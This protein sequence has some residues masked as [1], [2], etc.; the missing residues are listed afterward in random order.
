MLNI[1]NAS[2]VLCRTRPVSSHQSSTVTAPQPRSTRGVFI[3]WEICTR[4]PNVDMRREAVRLSSFKYC[5]LY[6]LQRFPTPH[7]LAAAGFF[8]RGLLDIMVCAFCDLIISK[9]KPHDSPMEEHERHSANCPFVLGLPVGNIPI[10]RPSS[11]Q[12][13][14]RPPIS[15]TTTPRRQKTKKEVTQGSKQS[16]GNAC[17]S[18]TAK[19]PSLQDALLCIICCDQK[20]S[21]AFLP[22]GHSCCCSSCAT[23]FTNCPMCR[24]QIEQTVRIYF[25]FSD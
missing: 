10:S 17:E 18:A 24:K 8:Y 11:G 6:V 9:W 25:P 15:S 12:K 21:E 3:D 5:S 4:D 22:C 20:F 23:A 19:Q 1:A 7:A 16:R 14:V 2:A 13:N